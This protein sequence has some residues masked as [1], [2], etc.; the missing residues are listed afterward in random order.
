MRK[1]TERKRAL[2]KKL[3]E[4]KDKRK[5]ERKGVGKETDRSERKIESHGTCKRFLCLFL[6]NF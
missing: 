4:G 2:N 6:D 3:R 1:T 5:R